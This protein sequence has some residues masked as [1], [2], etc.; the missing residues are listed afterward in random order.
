[1]LHV[2]GVPARASP[3]LRIGPLL[4]ALVSGLQF[5][6]GA[7]EK[8]P[9][10]VISDAELAGLTVRGRLGYRPDHDRSIYFAA[11]LLSLLAAMALAWLW[12]RRLSSVHG[13]DELQ[14]VHLI[15]LAHFP[16]AG[17]LAFLP[18]LWPVM[19]KLS[20]LSGVLGVAFCGAALWA[21]TRSTLSPSWW[22]RWPKI[23]R[24]GVET[25]LV[26]AL[27]VLLV[28]IP[29]TAQLAGRDYLLDHFHHMDYYMMAPALA[30]RHGIAL[31]TNFY[32]QY[33]VGWPMLLA[34]LSK[35][36]PLSYQLL[37]RVCVVWGCLYFG[38]VF[39]FLRLLLRSASW[40]TAGLLLALAL[41]VFSGV[42]ASGLPVWVL[43]SS[44]VM[45]YSMD[46]CLFSVCLVHATSGKNWLGL[47]AGILA[48]LGILLGT[49]TGIYLATCLGAYVVLVPRLQ[50][51]ENSS[52]RAGTFAGGALLGF[53]GVLLPGLTI[54]SRGTLG[55]A[56]FWRGWTESLWR[57]SDGFT[58]LPIAAAL[59]EWSAYVQL[60]MMLLC[61][62]FAVLRMLEESLRR[63][64]TPRHLIVGLVAADG[65][66]TLLLFV[67]RSHPCNLYHAS[68]PFCL[69]ALSFLAEICGL[70]RR[71]AAS[72]N[73]KQQRVLWRA[74]LAIV[75][76]ACAYAALLSVC[77]CPDFCNYPNVLRW[78]VYDRK[79]SN[80]IPE[81]NY[82]FA[83]RHDAPLPD[84]CRDEVARFKAVTAEMRNLS[85]GGRK[86]VAM[87]DDRDTS[88]LVETD[89]RPYSRYSPVQPNLVFQSE[90]ADL[91]RQL[92]ADPPDYLFFVPGLADAA[93]ATF[94]DQHFTVIRGV[95]GKNIYRPNYRP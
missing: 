91:Q 86:R 92:V 23:Y 37:L 43:P 5:A 2:D 49:D 78:L 89:F 15:W 24:H 35:A 42:G 50:N 28:Y 70:L 20:F 76:W 65:L 75:P 56:E 94:V 77:V 26:T 29:D 80:Q 40:A 33:G 4:L 71:R 34:L 6:I 52:R 88:Y 8:W 61:Y 53:V 11:V 36:V 48:A 72:S 46:A 54:A 82:L 22:L 30:F 57:Y 9:Q 14:T 18:L 21:S 85:D 90:M 58:H 62:L 73:S 60:L 19:P 67:G 47:P 17:L 95:A 31:G 74:T 79:I 81:E 63:Q 41:Q 32:V 59:K 25:V 93:M 10:R 27:L 38:T 44:S 45:R 16:A 87:I 69:V 68:I 7:W 3:L 64:L 55:Q 13:G 12:R 1:L 84:G 66:G 39:L 51:R 83:S